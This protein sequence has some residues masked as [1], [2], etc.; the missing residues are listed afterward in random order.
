MSLNPTSIGERASRTKTITDADVQDFARASGDTN[1]VHLNDAYAAGT[2]FGRRIA[3]GMLT[4][5][6]I[7]A[8][9]G[10][11]LPGHGTIYLGQDLKF[12]AP[13]FVGDTVTAT[14]E[15]IKFREDKRIATFQTTVTNGD[16]VVVIEGE[17]VVIAP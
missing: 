10:N 3:H 14:V 4:A 9:L 7:S 13:V 1:P 15:L 17:A 6:L 5:S 8:I 11:D 12:R 2:R 16:G